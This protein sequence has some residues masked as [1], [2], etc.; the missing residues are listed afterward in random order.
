MLSID[1]FIAMGI[2]FLLFLRHLSVYKE[3]NKINYTPVVL[4]L[5]ILG[6]I[7]HLIFE[8]LSLT[9]LKE[10]ML[11]LSVGLVLFAIMSLISQTLT[12]INTHEDR[13][14]SLAIS[15]QLT[16]LGL[17]I[18][19][20]KDHLDMVAKMES[21]THE[22]LRTVFK[23]EIDALNVIQ[24]NQKLFVAKIE[25]L[26]AHQQSTMEKFED[27][28]LSELPSLD[29]VIH[30][31]ID[32]L[33]VAEQDHFNK[34]KNVVRLS[35]DE[36]KEVHSQLAEL[37]ET[38]LKIASHQTPDYTISVLQKELD[39]IVHDFDRHM[40]TLGA[41]SET[42][43]STLHENEAIL[44]NSR[45]ESE[46]IMR[47]MVLSS[48]Q[49]KEMSLHSKELAESLEPLSH[50]FAS[51]KSLHHEFVTARGRLSEL[52]VTLESY[53]RQEYRTIRQSLEEVAAQATA[54]MELFIQNIQKHEK[55]PLIET[56][57]VQDLAS[58]VKLQKS[59]LGDNQE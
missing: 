35:C 10:A 8:E 34:L 58:K 37:R 45:E 16:A 36:Q 30:R 24:S 20:L 22:Q 29:N 7:F 28:T 48:K 12:V 53:E 25:A 21:S 42:I 5:G 57:N 3:P 15:D 18:T 26:L 44:K 9:T 23:E 49:M 39:R 1:L 52:I 59:Y 11:P 38:V 46:M 19:T 6:A 17:S 4:T 40:Q 47:Q 32:L 31:H 14:R 56:K 54:Q 41:K 55:M 2:I 50:L 27:F 43:L 51:A 13:L 33:R